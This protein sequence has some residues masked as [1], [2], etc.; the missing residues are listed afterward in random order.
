MCIRDRPRTRRKSTPTT[1]NR[2][3]RTPAHRNGTYPGD[4]TGRTTLSYDPHEGKLADPGEVIWTWVPYEEDH[5]QGKDRPV[6]VVGRDRDY[7]L[8]VPMTSKDHDL[9]AAQEAEEGRYWVEV[10]R[11]AWDLSLIHI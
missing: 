4:F 2:A 7:L 11:G 9:D 10:G 8:A 6:L 3:R 5:T 1:T